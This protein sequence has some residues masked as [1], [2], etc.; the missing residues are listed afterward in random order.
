VWHHSDETALY[1][2]NTPISAARAAQAIRAHWAIETTSHYCR[3]VTISEN[4]TRIRS[5]PG[6]FASRRSFAFNILM[7]NRSQTLHQYRYRVP[8][9]DFNH[10][11]ICSKSASVEQP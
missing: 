8:S 5:N 4:R 6:V 1:V 2:A 11:S 9:E 7:A 3:D 10:S